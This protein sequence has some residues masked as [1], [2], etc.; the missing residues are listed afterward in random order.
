MFESGPPTRLSQNTLVKHISYLVKVI[1]K[2]H[3]PGPI[4]EGLAV[5][6]KHTSQSIRCGD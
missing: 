5:E 4:G 2:P 3:S 6:K 1:S